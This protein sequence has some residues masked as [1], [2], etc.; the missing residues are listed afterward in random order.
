MDNKWNVLS[1]QMKKEDALLGSQVEPDLLEHALEQGYAQIRERDGCIVSFGALWPREGALELGSLWVSS[2]WRGHKFGSDVFASLLAQAT[3]D[4]PLFLITH[5][6]HVVHLA[7]KHNMEEAS[8]MDWANVV[9]WS[10]S[11]GLCDRLPDAQ[12]PLC[13]FKAVPSECRLFFKS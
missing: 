12:K 6:P 5:V 1:Q 2:T 7:L 8:A 4:R 10:A 11:C 9:P 3:R 13:Q